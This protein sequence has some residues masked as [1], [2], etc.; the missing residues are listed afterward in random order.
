MNIPDPFAVG[1]S[2]IVPI[3]ANSCC[4][5]I[6]VGEVYS[7]TTPPTVDFLQYPVKSG[8]MPG[9][10]PVYG[11]GTKTIAKGLVAVFTSPRGGYVPGQVVG[12]LKVTPSGSS[13]FQ[14][15]EQEKI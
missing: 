12:G 11:S 10:T 5:R 2:A 1:A 15:E 13:T 7:S 9:Q 6:V 14:Q 3:V 8:D 4:K